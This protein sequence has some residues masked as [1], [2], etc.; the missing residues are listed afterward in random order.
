MHFAAY[1]YVGE[2]CHTPLAYYNTN[3]VGSISLLS[4]IAEAGV[5]RIV[6]SSTCATYGEPPADLIPISETCEQRPINPYGRSKLAF[7]QV[8]K[9]LAESDEAPHGF[10]FAILRYFNIAG[11]DPRGRVGEDHQPE[12]HLIPRCLQAALDDHQVIT[13]FGTDYPTDD[14][15]CI[16]DYVHVDDLVDAHVK[17]LESLKPGDG[18]IFNI[19]TG[20]GYSVLDVI[21]ACKKITGVNFRTN[22]GIRRKGD[23]P[24]LYADP[25]CIQKEM[26]WR[27]KYTGIE[28]MIADAWK[29]MLK[30]PHGYKEDD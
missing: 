18:K 15:T 13:I 2:S 19:G 16:R 29:W 9:D 10:C 4:A 30:N 27:S 11:A 26:G 7:E 3:L 24:V 28:T 21:R 1:A 17:V 12:T 8:L 14:G 6:F 20:R 22:N 5:T 25:T 23:P